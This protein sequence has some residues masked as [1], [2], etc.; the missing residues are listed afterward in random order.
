MVDLLI[1]RRD[2]TATPAF[3]PWFRGKTWDRTPGGGWYMMY[4]GDGI[5]SH[6]DSYLPGATV[7]ILPADP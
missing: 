1:L 5:V 6:R 3:F 2:A 7:E 4:D